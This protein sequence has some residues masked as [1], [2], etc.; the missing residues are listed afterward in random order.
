MI[1]DK[2][3]IACACFEKCGTHVAKGSMICISN[4]MNA[5]QSKAD[6]YKRMQKGGVEDGRCEVDKNHN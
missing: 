5:G 4:R 1:I 2:E 6:M 3:C